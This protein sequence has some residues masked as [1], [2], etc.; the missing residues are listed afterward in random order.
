[1]L[2]K[3]QFRVVDLPFGKEKLA[4]DQNIMAQ[5]PFL[6]IPKSVEP[7]YFKEER[8]PIVIAALVHLVMSHRGESF[9]TVLSGG[10]KNFESLKDYTSK[11]MGSGVAW[12]VQK[13]RV[14]LD[15]IPYTTEYLS[16]YWIGQEDMFDIHG[17]PIH[18]W[19]GEIPT[20]AAY[21]RDKFVKNRVLVPEGKT[22][23]GIVT[24]SDKLR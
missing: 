22:P 14:F 9:S 18:G 1:M 19:P 15:A 8:N 12:V 7:G 20:F 24:T 23:F 13:T 6:D 10:V 17:V 2:P 4:A 5:R 11:P 16:D 3:E 21:Q